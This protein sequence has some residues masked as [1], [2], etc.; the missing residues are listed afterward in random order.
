MKGNN[1]PTSALGKG[2]SKLG[3]A[4]GGRGRGRGS[5]VQKQDDESSPTPRGRGRGG[6]GRGGMGRGRGRGGVDL[7]NVGK[8]LAKK[9]DEGLATPATPADNT[10][11]NTFTSIPAS[12]VKSKFTDKEEPLRKVE[13]EKK[14]EP[15]EEKKE[16]QKEGSVGR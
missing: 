7:T 6:P 4:P 13:E 14:E 16:E 2:G 10:A 1:T 5:S 15:K 12:T 11:G 3:Q 9:Q 8:H